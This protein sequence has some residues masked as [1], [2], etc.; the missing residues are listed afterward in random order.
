[1]TF[2]WYRLFS[3]PDFLATGL[4]SRTLAV[5]LEG[6]G[7]KSILIT[8]GNA[9]GITY[10]DEFLPIGSIGK[11]PYVR[12]SYA[13]YKDAED[14]VWLGIEAE[15]GSETPSESPSEDDEES[16]TSVARSVI[17]AGVAHHV[18]VNDS[19]GR[20]SS[21]SKLP[22]ER[23]GTNQSSYDQGDLLY[24]VEDDE[25]GKLPKGTANRKLAMN[26]GATAPVWVPGFTLGS[27]QVFTSPGT[28]DWTKPAGCVAVFVEVVGS[29]GAGGGCATTVG[30]EASDAGGGGGGE[31]AN[32][33]ITS[34]LGA[35]ETVVVGAGGSPGSAGNNPGGNGNPSSFGSHVSANG[36]NGGNG[37]AAAS[38]SGLSAGGAGG[39]GGSGGDS[40][41]PGSD[42][43]NGRN[44]AGIRY[45][46]GWGGASHMSGMRQAPSSAG[47]GNAGKAHGGGGSGASLAASTSAVA[48]GAGNKGAVI[49]WEFY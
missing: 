19:L 7:E 46:L 14:F 18:V 25:L 30:G 9:V 31:Y 1:M 32:K 5:S 15:G 42:G 43:G 35:T 8:R 3:L 37:S 41:I 13:V 45:A 34:G 29:G 16:H 24:A 38:G 10:E 48:G 39:T 6:I 20:L 27:K 36:G 2:D 33:W 4:V 40:A 49:V 23:G 28:T 47:A 11:N 44:A 17:A 21:V 26:P 12:S 22:E